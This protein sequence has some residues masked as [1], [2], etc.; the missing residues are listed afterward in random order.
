[1]S[2][3]PEADPGS[4]GVC[5]QSSWDQKRPARRWGEHPGAPVALMPCLLFPSFLVADS[6]VPQEP[7]HPSMIE[8]W[9]PLLPCTRALGIAQLLTWGGKVGGGMAPWESGQPW[10]RS[11]TGW[12]PRAGSLCQARSPWG[13]AGCSRDWLNLLST[14]LL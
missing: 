7:G 11:G 3:C 2:Q 1:V 9:H 6:E 10:E 4:Q 5:V 12:V 13:G 14:W 8:N